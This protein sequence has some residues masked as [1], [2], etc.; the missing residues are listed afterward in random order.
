MC[1]YNRRMKDVVAHDCGFD[2]NDKLGPVY[3]LLWQEKSIVEI[4]MKLHISESTVNRRIR[5]IKRH[6][7]TL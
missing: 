4:S 6:I 5:E 1:D 2:T 7:E 3:E